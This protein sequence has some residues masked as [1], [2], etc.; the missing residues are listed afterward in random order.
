MIRQSQTIICDAQQCNARHTCMMWLN[1]DAH[2]PL[3]EAIEA[4]W[5]ILSSPTHAGKRFFCPEHKA[6]Q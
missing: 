2:T 4:G 6:D 1:S 5:R 3:L